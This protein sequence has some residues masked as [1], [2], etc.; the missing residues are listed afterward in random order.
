[1]GLGE[2]VRKEVGRR[3]HANALRELEALNRNLRSL[4]ITLPPP[5]A[6]HVRKSVGK[7][8]PRGG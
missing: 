3:P 7:A 8:Q 2:K 5:D 6:G 4:G 1:M